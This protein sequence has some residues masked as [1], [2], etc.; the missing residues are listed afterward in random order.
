MNDD[1]VIVSAAVSC[2]GSRPQRELRPHLIPA[3]RKR[4]E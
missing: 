3:I 2:L 1:D 4:Y